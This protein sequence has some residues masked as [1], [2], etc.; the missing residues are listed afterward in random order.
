MIPLCA[1]LLPPPR[2][3]RP[4]LD[5]PAHR[6]VRHLQH[7]R[8]GVPHGVLA[9]RLRNPGA[10]DIL[11]ANG[12]SG[13]T[14]SEAQ[15][16]YKADGGVTDPTVKSAIE[17][18]SRISPRNS[19]MPPLP[20]PTPP[21]GRARISQN[22]QIA[23][24]RST[25]RT[26]PGELRRRRQGIKALGDDVHVAR[27]ADRVRRRHVRTQIHARERGHRHRSRRS[28]SC[29]S[30]SARCWRW[31]CR[32]SPRSSASAC[33]VALVGARPRALRRAG[34]ATPAG[35]DD[36]PRRRHRLRPVHRHPLPREPARRLEPEDAVVARDRH[37]RPRR[38]L[39]RHHRG[40]LAARHVPHGPRRSSAAVAR[41]RR[42]S[43]C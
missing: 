9:P 31:A 15:I 3:R 11:K 29:S 1:L 41:R 32:S 24:A 21:R 30:P 2:Y 43:P 33:G 16:V 20:V 35:G 17:V 13:H 22:G 6:A 28:S 12:F 14:G 36:R 7:L 18:C 25:S 42:R 23:Y 34:F 26:A 37:R 39:R 5:W 27:P 4:L 10:S 8:R 19:R 38:A 40:H